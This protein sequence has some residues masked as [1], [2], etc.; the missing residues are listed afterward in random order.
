MLSDTFIKTSRIVF[1]PV[2]YIMAAG[3]VL[4]LL[5]PPYRKRFFLPLAL[6]LVFMF[7]WRCCITMLSAR[8]AAI[9]I[10]AALDFSAYAAY[11]LTPFLT[12]A[13]FILRTAVSLFSASPYAP[14]RK[15]S[16]AGDH[17]YLYRQVPE[18][19]PV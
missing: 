13:F 3:M 18:I 2:F 7:S 16:A 5:N 11:R 4:A 19:Q 9:F 8:Y 17:P 10:Y 12:A 1:E 6:A 15:N 14:C